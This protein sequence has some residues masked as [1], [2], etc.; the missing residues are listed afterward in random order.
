[1]L[2]SLNLG[3]IRG[4]LVSLYHEVGAGRKPYPPVARAQFKKPKKCGGLIDGE[5]FYYDE[6]SDNRSNASYISE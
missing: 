4:F 3:C 1:V 6:A 5:G 2:D